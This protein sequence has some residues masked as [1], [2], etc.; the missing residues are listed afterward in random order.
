MYKWQIILTMPLFELSLVP[1]LVIMVTAIL[2]FPVQ[3]T[4]WTVHTQICR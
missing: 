2:F 3:I 4:I 1:I